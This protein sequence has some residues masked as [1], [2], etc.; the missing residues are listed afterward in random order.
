M[1]KAEGNSRPGPPSWL[2]KDF[3]QRVLRSQDGDPTITVTSYEVS[4]AN[5]DGDGYLS[6]MYRIIATLQDSQERRVIVK[7]QPL[8]GQREELIE[9]LDAFAKETQMLSETLPRMHRLLE[10]AKPGV[11]PPF[12]AKCLHHGKEPIPFIVMED[13]RESGFT[14]A[15]R[16]LGFDLAHCTLAMKTLARMHASSLALYDKN[17]EAVKCF[18]CPVR[19]DTR[20]VLAPFYQNAV[21]S[22]ADEVAKWPGFE[23]YVPKLNKLVDTMFDR[24]VQCYIRKEDELNVLCHGDTWCNNMMFKYSNDTL[25]D[26]RFVDLQVSFFSSPALDLHNFLYSSASEEVRINHIDSLLEDYHT[27]FTETLRIL[28]CSKYAVSLEQLRKIFKDY[29][30]YGFFISTTILPVAILEPELSFDVEGALSKSEGSSG[31]NANMY[32]NKVYVNTM[33]RLFPLFE[34]DGLLD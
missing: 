3:I 10:Q 18:S 30:F 32:E 7:C 11:Y 31:K 21:R 17:P 23:E 16:Q 27:S 25:E 34:K 24:V 19:E 14:L 2:D 20:E 29:A 6:Y 15:T 28:N 33:K 5:A 22:L 12:T 1:V 4:M 13:L 8:G 9:S 26:M